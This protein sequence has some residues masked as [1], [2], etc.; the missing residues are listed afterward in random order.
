M[1]TIRRS[2]E[3]ANTIVE[4]TNSNYKTCYAAIHEVTCRLFI[5][6]APGATRRN[7]N[8]KSK[9]SS[10]VTS[11]ES[12]GN[13]VA[14]RSHPTT[15]LTIKSNEGNHFWSQVLRQSLISFCKQLNSANLTRFAVAFAALTL[16]HPPLK[17]G[18]VLHGLWR[19]WH[20]C[21]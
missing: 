2:V 1:K 3:Y 16:M 12:C 20:L 9:S 10:N 17:Q 5:Y 21:P 18:E 7:W 19:K 4:V 6:A 15:S 8:E 11:V 14:T 13:A